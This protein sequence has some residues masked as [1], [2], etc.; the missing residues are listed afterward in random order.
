MNSGL[1]DIFPMILVAALIALTLSPLISRLATRVRLVDVPGSAAHKLHQVTMPLSGGLVAAATLAG[2][3]AILRP[4]VTGHIRGMAVGGIFVL[5]WGVLDDKVNLPVVAKLAGQLAAALL[6]INFGVQVRITQMPAVDLALSMLWMVGLINAFNFIDSMDGLALGIGSVALA[7][8]MLVTLD[9]GQPELAA[10]SAATLGAAVGL[11]FFNSSPATLFLG[12]SGAQV[13]GF[14]LAAVGIAYVPAGAG[15]PQALSWFTPILVLGV[16]IF[17]ATLVVVSRLRRGLPVYQAQ[18]DHTYHRL[19][20][21]GLS[22]SRSVLAMHMAAIMLGLI[23][24]V[25]LGMTVLLANA[26]FFGIVLIG[27]LIMIYMEHSFRTHGSRASI[28]Y[29]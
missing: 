1:V 21:L 12:D 15:L 29:R 18:H 23:A 2:T 20:A 10:I 19:V 24:F 13:L 22:P 6:L 27:V 7:F 16:P 28:D 25:A 5:V 17:D 9:A 14:I 11:F 4:P 3:Y 8:F 26:I